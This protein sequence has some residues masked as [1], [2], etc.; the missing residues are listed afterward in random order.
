MPTFI[1]TFVNVCVLAISASMNTTAE[2]GGVLR[3]AASS[4]PDF[5]SRLLQIVYFVVTLAFAA[6][7]SSV[8]TRSMLHGRAMSKF[9]M[10]NNTV[11]EYLSDCRGLIQKGIR[12]HGSKPFGLWTGM[13]TILIIPSKYH[14]ELR[15]D[16]RIGTREALIHVRLPTPPSHSR[17]PTHI[18]SCLH[19]PISKSAVMAKTDLNAMAVVVFPWLH[20]RDG[21][22]LGIN[23]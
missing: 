6:V 7:L 8:A 14:E 21:G 23:D 16:H 18:Q 2:S 3:M 11:S 13:R 1:C 17:P 9:P 4:R 10:M 20:I 12:Q 5:N 22:V 15:N 19:P